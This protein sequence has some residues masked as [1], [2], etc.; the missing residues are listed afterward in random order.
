[1][2]E[3]E[4]KD[5]EQKILDEYKTP[6][7]G[8]VFGLTEI[9]IAIFICFIAFVLTGCKAVKPLIEYRDSICY[10][11]V[12]DTTK[13]FIHDSI[14]RYIKEDTVFLT[15]WR[16]KEVE[17]I[18]HDTINI[19][20]SDKEPYEVEVIKEVVPDWCWWLLAIVA[21]FV[22]YKI[23]RFAIKIYAKGKV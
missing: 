1:M 3:Q 23:V 14:D 9:V 17:K 6:P 11:A 15:K 4:R 20:T 2:N 8:C 7:S 22:G 12:H 21:V 5:L 13:T 16:Y 19:G 18:K 10:V